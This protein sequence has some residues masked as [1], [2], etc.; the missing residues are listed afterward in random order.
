LREP[1]VGRRFTGVQLGSSIERLAV[2][3]PLE[4]RSAAF[5]QIRFPKR[6]KRRPAR[7]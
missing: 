5:K 2:E 6:D 1:L 4:E 7:P 3:Q